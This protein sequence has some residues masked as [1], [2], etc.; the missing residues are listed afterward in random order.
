MVAG[1]LNVES[2]GARKLTSLSNSRIVV[3]E[4][5]IRKNGSMEAARDKVK[6]LLLRN[7][8]SM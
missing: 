4:V 5:D 6:D 8:M 2:D 7:R 1:C 3:V